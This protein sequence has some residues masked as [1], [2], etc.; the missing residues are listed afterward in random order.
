MYIGDYP[1][2]LLIT[3]CK[4]GT[5]PKCDISPTDIRNE[6]DPDYPLHHLP[7]VLS[8]LREVDNTATASSCACWE[9][10]IK[11]VHHPF[12][13]KLL[14]VNVFLLIT[15][16]ILH[17]L[18]QG[19]IKHILRW[20]KVA[21]GT[22]ELDVCCHYLP[23]NHQ[24]QLFLKGITTL[25]QVTGKEHAQIS[26]FLLG[27]IIGLPLCSGFSP[28]WLVCAIYAILGFLYLAQY[29]AHMS[30]TLI[31]LCTAL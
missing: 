25:Q 12:W 22:E 14:Y 16:D 7:D 13:E 20:L 2:Q 6:T 4:N 26:C 18:H 5:C 9:A 23:P 3:C 11:P 17:Q 24:I 31:Q 15:P 1:E 19:V 30:K 10:G 29:P 28:T 27:L 21:Y 8:T